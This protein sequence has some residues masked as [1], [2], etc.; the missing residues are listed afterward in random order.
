ML[1]SDDVCESDGGEGLRRG[2]D[3]TTV[4]TRAL[5]ERAAEAYAV[6]NVGK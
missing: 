6:R 4:E 5:Y 3:E 1:M 2:D